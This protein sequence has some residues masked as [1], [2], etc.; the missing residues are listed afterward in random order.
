MRCAPGGSPRYLGPSLYEYGLFL[1]HTQHRDEALAAFREA[2]DVRRASGASST[3]QVALIELAYGEALLASGVAAG[4]RARAVAAIARLEA[5]PQGQ[6]AALAKG[7]AL[8]ERCDGA[9]GK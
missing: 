9:G 8:L 7:R 1:W 6:D 4:A 2:V 5:A 3:P